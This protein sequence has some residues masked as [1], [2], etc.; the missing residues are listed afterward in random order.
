MRL[1]TGLYLIAAIAF[2]ASAQSIAISGK[3]TNK[4]SGKPVAGATI[5]LKGKN[6]SAATDA[7]G[8]YSIVGTALVAPEPIMP[9]AES[10]TMNN[11][12]VSISL[13]AAS[14]VRIELFDMKGNLLGKGINR[15]ASAGNYRF[16]LATNPLA[17]K[18]MIIRLSIGQRTSTFRHLPINGGKCALA[19][20]TLP[21]SGERLAKMQ[22]TVDSLKVTASNYTSAAVAISTYQ[23]TGVNIALDSIT[24]TLD[25]F[26][27]FVTSLKGLQT[28]SGSEKGF[29]GDF[30]MG[31]TGDGAGL[32][33]A[34]SICQCLA[35][36]SMPGSKVKQ[37]RAFL[38]VSK[39]PDGKQVNAIDRIGQG[40]WYDRIG[41]LLSNNITE[42]KNTRPAGADVAIKNDLPN[43]DGVPNHTPV[44]GQASQDNH[45]F[46]TGSTT[47]GTLYA[48][49]TCQDWTSVSTSDKARCGFSW[50]RTS[51]GSAAHWISG[52]DTP[53]CAAGIEITN[54]MGGGSGGIIGG[55]GGY[56]GFYCFALNP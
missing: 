29:G 10:I 22:A 31:K 21:L 51:T 18:M 33:G 38:S 25:K 8:T 54:T 13:P 44:P 5:T 1:K 50:P 41:R 28:L 9:I 12:I 42:L 53:G 11:G 39:G 45:H 2:T 26:S 34:D 14:P 48:N 19:S 20:T 4:S 30:R 3:V 56:G 6:L 43:E 40:P 27:F 32:L 37:W 16:N 35:E 17:V 36:K 52:W 15:T 46:A 49:E 24:I 47:T 23:Q 55:G 7:N